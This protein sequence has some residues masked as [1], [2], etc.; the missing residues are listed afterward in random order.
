MA[1]PVNVKSRAAK[2]SV[3]STS[4][5]KAASGC[6]SVKPQSGRLA[7]SK[8]N[9]HSITPK[10]SGRVANGVSVSDSPGMRKT[11]VPDPPKEIET[12]S[13]VIYEF[14]TDKG[15]AWLKA[16]NTYYTKLYKGKQAGAPPAAP[17]ER[18]VLAAGTIAVTI[19]KDRH[20]IYLRF[21]FSYC[22]SKVQ[23]DGFNA[24]EWRDSHYEKLLSLVESVSI[25]HSLIL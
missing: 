25:Y 4:K 11:S 1:P 10:G 24:K 6:S 7:G 15:K 21:T 9:G 14:C 23:V 5:K 12:E 8:E 22:L 20:P 16:C 13:G 3:A 19:R 2:S 17:L 18:P